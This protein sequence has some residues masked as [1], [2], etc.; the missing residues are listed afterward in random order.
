MR[1]LNFDLNDHKNFSSLK[2]TLHATTFTTDRRQRREE[3]NREIGG[4]DEE[5]VG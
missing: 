3:G 5:V 4:G 2:P 1:F